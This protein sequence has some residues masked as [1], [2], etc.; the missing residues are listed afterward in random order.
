MWQAGRMGY[1]AKGT[2]Q[3]VPSGVGRQGGGHSPSWDRVGEVSG[4]EVP[5]G[6]C[7]AEPPGLQGQP[8]VEEAADRVGLLA[9]SPCQGLPAGLMPSS[10]GLWVRWLRRAVPRAGG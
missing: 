6:V 3:W 4:D 8:G 9:H 5:A 10:S 7:P 2:F 1:K